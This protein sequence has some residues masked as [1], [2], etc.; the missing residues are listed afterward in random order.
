MI[1][2]SC[3]ICVASINFIYFRQ[4]F[5]GCYFFCRMEPCHGLKKCQFPVYFILIDDFFTSMVDEDYAKNFLLMVGFEPG[6][7]GDRF[8]DSATT[9]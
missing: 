7:G 2:L 5:L 3:R 6:I 4:F 8:T 1:D 9:T